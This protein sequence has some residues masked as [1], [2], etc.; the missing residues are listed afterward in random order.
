MESQ[1]LPN[2]W[3][4]NLRYHRLSPEDCAVQSMEDAS[5]VKWHLAHTTWF[6][7]S[8]WLERFETPHRP[9]RREYR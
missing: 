4:A 3:H 7:E 5:P 1:L 8:F 6:F 2:K 9:F